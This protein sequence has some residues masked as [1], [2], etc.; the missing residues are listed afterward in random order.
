[1]L[2]FSGSFASTHIPTHKWTPEN[3]L[4]RRATRSYSTTPVRTT[5]DG[6]TAPK[7]KRHN[8]ARPQKPTTI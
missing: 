2:A 5:K 6:R 3:S 8:F 4:T 7:A 1:M